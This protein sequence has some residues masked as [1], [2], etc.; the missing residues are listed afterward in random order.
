MSVPLSSGYENPIEMVA[1]PSYTALY[2]GNEL[3]DYTSHYKEGELSSSI[4]PF[5]LSESYLFNCAGYD[6]IMSFEQNEGYDTDNDGRSDSIE[7]K[8]TAEPTSDPLDYSDPARRQ[9]IWF[10]GPSDPGVATSFMPTQRYSFGMDLFKQFTIE[11]WVRPENAV[12][13]AEQYILCRATNYGGWDYAHSNAVIRLNFALGI[14]TNGCAFAEFQDSTENSV[15]VTG[16]ALAN[17]TWVHLA[18]TYDGVTFTIYVNGVGDGTLGTSLIPANGIKTI[19]LDGQHVDD[20]SSRYSVLPCVTML[21]G[22]PSGAAAFDFDQASEG[23]A[24]FADDFFQGSVDEVRFWDGARPRSEISADY[25]KRYTIDDAKASRLAHFQGILA[26]NRRNDNAGNEVLKPEL[27]QHFNFSTLGGATETNYVQQVPA[28][29]AANVLEAVRRPDT[30]V[31]MD[32]LAKIGWWA[33]LGATPVGSAVYT[34]PHVVPWI[35]NTLAHLPALSGFVSDS[36]YWSEPYAGYTSARTHD[37]EQYSFPNTMNPY[38]F[39][40]NAHGGVSTIDD[41]ATGRLLL[42]P[43][44]KFRTFFINS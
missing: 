12:S 4:F 42:L 34:S 39:T 8:L 38:G 19:R 21:G 32:D 10:G 40:V 17:N 15:R 11:A 29:F 20:M 2:Y 13:S 7:L 37:I 27:V 30:S 9:S 24:T 44:N 43:D 35:E 33:R 26:N 23:W 14:D 28:G 31:R 25:L 18:A 22:R 16:R 41:Q 6:Y 1:S 36:V 3:A 5:T